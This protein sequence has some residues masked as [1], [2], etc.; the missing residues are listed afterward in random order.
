MNYII[1]LTM[2]IT[3]RGHDLLIRYSL[4]A[5]S[6]DSSATLVRRWVMII[7]FTKYR[8]FRVYKQRDD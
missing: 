6:V 4:Y 1:P 2:T 3:K 8:A 7:K 5:N